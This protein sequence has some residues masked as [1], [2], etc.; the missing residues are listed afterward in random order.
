MMTMTPLRAAGGSVQ[1]ILDYFRVDSLKG[2][3]VNE[4]GEKETPSIWRGKG[5]ALLGLEGRAVEDADFAALL[6]GFS[7]SHNG[8]PTQPLVQNAGDPNRR[9]GWDLT[10][11]LEKSLSAV[12]AHPTTSPERRS[13]IK[14]IHEA[15]VAKVLARIE[16][17]VEVRQGK[18]GNVRIGNVGLA[19]AVV[20]HF[21]NRGDD[22]KR[23]EPNLHSHA[24]V[25]N[26]GFTVDG[27]GQV[28]ANVVDFARVK[29]FKHAYG[30]LYRAEVAALAKNLG[31]TISQH[32]QRD[33]KN[34][35]TGD[36]FFRI[37]GVDETIRDALSGRTKAIKEHQERTGSGKET[38]NLATKN[39]KDEPPIDQLLDEW[40]KHYE[41]IYQQHPEQLQ[42][43]SHSALL[44]PGLVSNIDLSALPDD[45]E[46]LR[47]C[48]Q[49]SKSSF[50][51]RSDLLNEVSMA[52]VG[53]LDAD[54]VLKKTESLLSSQ[55]VHGFAKDK[56]HEQRFSSQAM[57]DLERSIVEKGLARK[58]D[59]NVRLDS[60]RVK[61]SIDQYLGNGGRLSDEQRR[62]AEIVLSESGGLVVL[63]GRAGV[64][65]TA[66]MKAIVQA[67][68]NEGWTIHGTSTSSQASAKLEAES[69][70]PSRSAESMV[71]A[72]AKGS[73]RLDNKSV[74]V[75]DEA[76]MG[77][78]EHIAKIQDACD[79]A[80][81]KLILSGDVLQLQ[82]VAA[83]AP[84][85]TLVAELGA[86]EIKTI[87]R[88]STQR[89]RDTANLFYDGKGQAIMERLVE[90][91]H[92]V[93]TATDREALEKLVSDYC[94]SPRP[95]DEKIVLAGTRYDVQA[96]NVEIHR[97]MRKAGV[98]QGEDHDVR[99]VRDGEWSRLT[100]AQGDR[101]T[102]T[103]S[104]RETGVINGDGGVIEAIQR[105][106]E[107][108]RMRVRLI[109]DIE[110]KNGQVVEFSTQ[111]CPDLN[112]NYAM[113]VHKSQGQGKSEVFWYV[114]ES[115]LSMLDNQLSLVSFTR[116]K[117]SL[118]IYASNDVV[119]GEEDDNGQRHGGMIDRV[120]EV[121]L[122]KTTLDERAIGKEILDRNLAPLPTPT[123]IKTLAERKAEAAADA[124]LAEERA[125]A[126]H[127]RREAEATQITTQ[128]AKP[129][130]AS[131][132]PLLIEID[133]DEPTPVVAKPD[134]R[135]AQPS[136][137]AVD[138]KE[139]VKALEQGPAP[140]IPPK[141]IKLPKVQI[142]RTL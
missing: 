66:S 108:H 99:V 25:N 19:T 62:A 36:T 53:V 38:A 8:A 71:R 135:P 7:P 4:R 9:L 112:L 15:A 54:E 52:Y 74:V 129:I 3:Y 124:A 138:L 37:E 51:R 14:A 134:R 121:N 105:E 79:E 103:E 42:F 87:R 76:G 13:E 115:G 75:F 26:L 18:G 140:V 78:N 141:Q 31:Y 45:D 110:A 101:I 41:T 139:T 120:G 20:T 69:G 119:L 17:D 80:G 91:Q 33:V 44:R 82:P 27:K 126:E 58:G 72:L 67:Y 73:L 125:R 70:I 32:E 57:I 118:T 109:S 24:I 6:M 39:D 30:A 40:S 117:D 50:F 128:A 47:R 61:S 89:Y 35:P 85:R 12:F 94:A 63:Q 96:I 21:G 88:Q 64:G 93:S 113:T 65:K 90:D 137:A 55:L 22:K 107:H 2:Y 106:G 142:G 132:H 5:A 1:H 104:N 16:A 133:L 34:R 56:Q 43:T 68:E 127:K 60:E 95:H 114:S 97:E 130:V 49:R 116:A 92:I 123:T 29:I 98:L 23:V 81:A 28:K 83:G 84:M 111:E 11:S 10:F 136:K 100:V 48:H 122:K 46:L 86:A 77:A 102:F 131:P 59:T